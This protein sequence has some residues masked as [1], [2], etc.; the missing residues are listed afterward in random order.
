MCIKCIRKYSIYLGNE[1]WAKVKRLMTMLLGEECKELATFKHSNALI[2]STWE[3]QRKAYHDVHKDLVS[4][5]VMKPIFKYISNRFD[6][7]MN[8]ENLTNAMRQ[9]NELYEKIFQFE[10]H[11]HGGNEHA[12]VKCLYKNKGG[13]QT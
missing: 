1:E 4:R 5:N 10:L 11:C 12:A 6:Q 9:R 13:C 8:F 3:D 7:Y 2:S